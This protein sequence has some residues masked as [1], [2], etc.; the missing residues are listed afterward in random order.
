MFFF[1]L[2]LGID[3]KIKLE[4]MLNENWNLLYYFSKGGTTKYKNCSSFIFD[5]YLEVS[6]EQSKMLGAFVLRSRRQTHPVTYI[7]TYV[8]MCRYIYL[9]VIVVLFVII[10]HYIIQR[11]QKA[12]PSSI[13]FWNFCFR[14]L[15]NLLRLLAA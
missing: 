12:K 10:M 15:L 1:I 3:K 5:F 14:N 11:A 13:L 2:S 4:N 9:N 7:H 8:Y 6:F